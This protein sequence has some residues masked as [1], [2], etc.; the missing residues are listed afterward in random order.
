MAW[1]PKCKYEYREGITVCADCKIPLV[2]ELTDEIIR[3]NI[4]NDEPENISYD[5]E[6]I[7]FNMDEEQLDEET[8]EQ[9]RKE[10]SIHTYQNKKN[11]AEDFKSSAYTLLIVGIAG[12]VALVLMELHIIPV[13]LAAPGKYITYGVMGALFLI[14]IV[15]GIHSFTSAKKYAY[16]AETE[17]ELTEQ[18]NKW[19]KETLTKEK[20]EQ[21]TSVADDLPDEMKYFKYFATLKAMISK[22]FGE[23]DPS[24]L[25]SLA[26]EVYSDLFD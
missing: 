12:I 9:I 13:S 26:E 8:I 16:E 24:Y 4:D 25:E 20:I 23:L 2:D 3:A 22:Q 1:C 19:C 18:I 21:S 11:K 6:Q 14:F 17:D 10:R 7:T 5:E 15:A